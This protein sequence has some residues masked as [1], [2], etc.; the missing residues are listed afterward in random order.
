MREAIITTSSSPMVTVAVFDNPLSAQLAKGRLE[1][2]GIACFLANEHVVAAN[3]LYANA[4]GG[5]QLQVRA[6]D[7]DQARDLLRS[8]PELVPGDDF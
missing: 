4:V 7:L 2:A 5:L 1:S 3:P 6:E 8:L